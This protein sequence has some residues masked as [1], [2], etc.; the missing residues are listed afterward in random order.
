MKKKQDDIIKDDGGGNSLKDKTQSGVETITS[1]GAKNIN[2]SIE[3]L[4]EKFEIAMEN[5]D[6]GLDEIEEKVA[7]AL[8]RAVN[9][10][11]QMA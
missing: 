5:I 2:I 6:Q 8:L 1:G 9:S 3:K 4:I 7:V 10:A 11:N